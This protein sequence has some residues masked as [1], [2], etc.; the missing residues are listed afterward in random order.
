MQGSFLVQLKV[1][2]ML[3]L[4]QR[5][6]DVADQKKQR[7]QSNSPYISLEERAYAHWVLSLDP[8][9]FEILSQTMDSADWRELTYIIY[10]IKDEMIDEWMDEYGTPDADRILLQLQQK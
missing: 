3:L 6:V 2:R 9:E 10:E 5:S 8:I 7:P 4:N 1:K